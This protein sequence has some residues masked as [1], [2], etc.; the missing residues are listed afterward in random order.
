MPHSLSHL[1]L[2]RV[3]SARPGES[4]CAALAGLL[5][6]V[7]IGAL[8]AIST[9]GSVAAVLAIPIRLLS[10]FL[11]QGLSILASCS[12]VRM[13]LVLAFAFAFAFLFSCAFHIFLCVFDL[14][15]F[16]WLFLCEGTESSEALVP[17]GCF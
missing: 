14:F 16:V 17:V 5:S 2:P 10:C 4:L 13:F 15:P 8:L 7:F 11:H 3:A 1:F 9:A 12:L 6:G